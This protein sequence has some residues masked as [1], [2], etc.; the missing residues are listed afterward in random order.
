[1]GGGAELDR[2]GDPVVGPARSVGGGVGLEQDAGMGQL[3]GGRLAGGDQLLKGL[4]F[5]GGQGDSVLLHG[6]PPEAGVAPGEPIRSQLTTQPWR[7]TSFT[8]AGISRPRASR[9]RPC[10]VRPWRS[11]S[12]PRGSPPGRS[13]SPPSAWSRPAPIPADAPPGPASGPSTFFLGWQNL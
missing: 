6:D 7:T 9:A 2:L 4:A 3:L 13:P 5:L 1:D 8:V 11:C 12:A 10:H